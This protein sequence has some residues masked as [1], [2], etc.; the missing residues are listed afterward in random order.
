[1]AEAG[2][3]K[4]GCGR[5]QRDPPSSGVSWWVFADHASRGARTA[6]VDHTP[7]LPGWPRT[8]SATRE[9]AILNREPY[10]CCR[11][12]LRRAREDRPH[13]P[14]EPLGIALVEP[15]KAYRQGRHETSDGRPAEHVAEEMRPAVHPLIS[16][17]QRQDAEQTPR[18]RIDANQGNR[19]ADGGGRVGRRKALARTAQRTQGQPRPKTAPHAAEEIEAD[20]A[21]HARSTSSP[22]R[23][24]GPIARPSPPRREWPNVATGQAATSRWRPAARTRPVR[25]F[26]RSTP[27][28]ADIADILSLWLSWNHCATEQS[29]LKAAMAPTIR[30]VAPRQQP[31]TDPARPAVGNGLSGR[32]PLGFVNGKCVGPETTDAF[33]A[34][35]IFSPQ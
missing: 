32:W 2:K 24:P 23:P 19:Q 21:A 20:A 26:R 4:V 30:I 11:L 6:P 15:P 25:R 5:V 9:R 28:R 31:Q 18:G 16:N 12:S 1:M 27:D 17:Q 33:C 34:V 10:T 8:R 35:C 29:T 22:R 3:R 7:R 14:P 13:S